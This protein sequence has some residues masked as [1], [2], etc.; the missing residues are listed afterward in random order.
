MISEVIF[1]AGGKERGFKFGTYTARLIEEKSGMKFSDF[2]S[3]MIGKT[4]DEE[5]EGDIVTKTIES[6]DLECQS[7]FYFCCALHYAK[8]KKIEVDFDQIE[9]DDWRDELGT[10]KVSEIS[11]ELFNQYSSKNLNPPMTGEATV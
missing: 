1:T 8:S 2:L 4:I 11:I 10:E 5:I 6:P 7:K 3:K 9:V